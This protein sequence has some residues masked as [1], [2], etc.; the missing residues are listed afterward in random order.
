MIVS[1]QGLYE[2]LNE[3]PFHPVLIPESLHPFTMAL[4]LVAECQTQSFRDGLSN[5]NK[6]VEKS[7][8]LAV[9]TSN[10]GAW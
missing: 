3:K 5:Q 9:S 2:S 4:H 8:L 6:L 7:N 10:F 1:S